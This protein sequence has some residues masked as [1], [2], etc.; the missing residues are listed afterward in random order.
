MI[1]PLPPLPEQHRIVAELEKQ[2]TRLDAAVAALKRAQANLK[3]YRAGVLKAACE[4][5]LVPTEAELARAERRHYEP[6]GRLLERIL[7]ERRARWQSGEKRRRKYKEPRRAG[8]L[9]LAG[10]ARGVGLGYSESDLSIVKGS[11]VTKGQR[12]P[13]G[14]S[15]RE[16]PYLRVANVQRG[17]LDLAHLKTIEVAQ[18]T[19]DQ[20]RL[21]Q[22]DILFTEGGDRDKLGRGWI[23]RGEVDECIHQNHVFRSRLLLDSIR[24]EIVSWWGNS[25]GKDFFSRGGKQTTKSGLNQP[26][27]A[28]TVPSSNSTFGRATPHRRRG[29]APAIGNTA[30]RNRRRC[31][32]EAGRPAAPEHPKAGILRPAGAPGP[33]RR[34]GLGIARANPGPA[35]SVPAGRQAPAAP[36]RTCSLS[37]WK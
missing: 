3:R 13:K 7:T 29:R 31:Q 37:L 33:Q 35:S 19:V 26:V 23:W 34:A 27:F 18:E 4:G 10:P 14:R 25:F 9:Q 21:V 28:C 16:I 30:S 22:G 12:H 24:P 17:Y 2:F 8:H 11:G 32:P 15:L 5:K 1:L 36:A 6:A 20:L